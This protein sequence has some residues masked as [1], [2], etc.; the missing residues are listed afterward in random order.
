MTEFEPHRAN[1]AP[2]NMPQRYIRQPEVLARVGVSWITLLRWERRGLFPKRRRLGPNTVAWL[3]H[4]IDSW[5]AS[6]TAAD[7][8]EAA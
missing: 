8:S 3:E 5:C 4:E 6:R 2:H 7:A 1:S